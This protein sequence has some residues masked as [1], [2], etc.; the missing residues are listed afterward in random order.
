MAAAGAQTRHVLLSDL[1]LHGGERFRYVYDFMANWE[2]DIRLEAFL[3][4]AP[5]LGV[6]PLYQWPPCAAARGL[7]GVPGPT[8]NGMIS[9]A[10]YPPFE[11]LGGGRCHQHAVKRGCADLGPGGAWGSGRTP[12]GRRL[13]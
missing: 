2:C 10:S 6:S 9:T 11:A 8:W 1:C 13:P 5:R 12:R 7:P 3:P 4:Q